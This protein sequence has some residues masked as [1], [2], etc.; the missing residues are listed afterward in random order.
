MFFCHSL[1]Q[2][3]V[4]SLL[5]IYLLLFY[6]TVILKITH[7]CMDTRAHIHGERNTKTMCPTRFEE[8]DPVLRVL[9][10]VFEVIEEIIRYNY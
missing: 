8:I 2:S 7:A 1:L 9:E 3:F 5:L 4:I 10:Y 6:H